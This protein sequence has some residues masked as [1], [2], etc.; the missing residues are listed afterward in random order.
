MRLEI[1]KKNPTNNIKKELIWIEKHETLNL[2]S[3]KKNKYDLLGNALF[4]I[5]ISVRRKKMPILQNQTQ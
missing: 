4:Q 1:L 5:G 2:L 3:V